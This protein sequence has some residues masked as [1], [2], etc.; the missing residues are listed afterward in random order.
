MAMSEWCDWPV[1]EE[2]T[3]WEDAQQILADA[4][5]SDGLPLV[6]PTRRASRRWSPAFPVAAS[7]AE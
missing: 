7:R 1:V 4:E 5:L 3:G 6:P 2:T